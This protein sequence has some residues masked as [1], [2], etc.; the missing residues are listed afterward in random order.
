MSKCKVKKCDCRLYKLFF[1]YLALHSLAGSTFYVL[2]LISRHLAWKAATYCYITIVLLKHFAIYYAGFRVIRDSAASLSIALLPEVWISFIY[3]HCHF[4]FE[5]AVLLPTQSLCRICNP[6]ASGFRFAYAC[7][8]EKT[9]CVFVGSA[10]H[11]GNLDYCLKRVH[12]PS[13]M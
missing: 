10:F 6:C 13:N 2:R 3:C 1:A 4:W 12:L 5:T 8:V 11:L 7:A 9:D